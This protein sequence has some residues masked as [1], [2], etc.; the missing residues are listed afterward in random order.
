MLH[1]RCVSFIFHDHF[2]QYTGW[3]SGNKPSFCSTLVIEE[4]VPSPKVKVI[5]NLSLD[6][7]PVSC[8]ISEGTK[9]SPSSN[10]FS[11]FI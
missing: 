1:P 9:Q 7:S 5:H 10:V 2:G 8:S 11:V 3:S 6:V 4:L